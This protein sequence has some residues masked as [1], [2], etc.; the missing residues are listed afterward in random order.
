MFTAFVIDPA[1][2]TITV[3]QTPGELSDL[4]T[5]IGCSSI[6][7]VEI[8]ETSAD[9]IYIDDE[10]LMPSDIRHFFG[11]SGFQQPLAG[12]AVLIG[13]TP[14]GDPTDVKTPLAVIMRNLIYFE[15]RVGRL[16][17]A[18]RATAPNWSYATV[19]ID[20]PNIIPDTFKP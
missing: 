10:G 2:R 20:D 4:R 12:K 8:D 15:M 5:L 1:S 3:T 18:Y 17:S 6:D 19:K 14:D 11:I 13:T 7:A 9:T 16:A